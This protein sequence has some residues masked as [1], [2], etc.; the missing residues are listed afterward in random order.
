[1]T[2]TAMKSMIGIENM[3]EYMKYQKRNMSGQETEA[4]ETA[5]TGMEN[6]LFR[7]IWNQ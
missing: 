3:G 5:V 7:M 1:M 2:L 6:C 4:A